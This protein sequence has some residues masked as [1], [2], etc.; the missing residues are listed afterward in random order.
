MAEDEKPVAK[1][2]AYYVARFKEVIRANKFNQTNRGVD[3]AGLFS[4]WLLT[5]T[6]EFPNISKFMEA[7]G[8]HIMSLAKRGGRTFWNE[9]RQA[10][11]MEAIGR[12]I[13]KAP[14]KLAARFDNLFRVQGK[15]EQAIERL[16]DRILDDLNQQE[17]PTGNAEE[18]RKVSRDRTT[19][20]ARMLERLKDVQNGLAD[21]A[22]KLG[23][24][25]QAGTGVSVN[26]Y[27][28]IVEGLR[29]RDA[30]N[31]VIDVQADRPDS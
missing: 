21:V 3:W 27:Q 17:A 22:A 16:A 5:D 13:E 31:G 28:S 11:R 25:A 23:G 30:E 14:D 1:D 12:Q 26:F 29:Q 19:F 6:S 8:V 7:R 18:D 2:R 9:A 20:N 24:N 4:E 10:A 15:L